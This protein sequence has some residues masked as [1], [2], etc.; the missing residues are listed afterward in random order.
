MNKDELHEARTN[1]EFLE[2]LEE[3]RLNSMK[4][5]DIS[6]MYETLDSMLVLD[7]EEEK[8]SKLYEQILNTAFEYVEKKINN[9]EKLTLNG[10]DLLYIRALYEHCI[11]KWSYDNYKGAKE[12]LFVMINI[13]D[14]K[15]LKEA[16]DIVL[17]FLSLQL[18]LDEFY[19][20]KVDLEASDDE[21]YGYFITKFNFDTNEFLKENKKI[22][23]TEYKN[24]KHLMEK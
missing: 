16:F 22:L 2:Y 21:V 12:L 24:L 9:E 4:A 5:K 1:P 7:L 15:I 8:I 10:D 6:L 3:A 18:S 23:K 20:T 11:E 19:D 17:V 13:V 14:D